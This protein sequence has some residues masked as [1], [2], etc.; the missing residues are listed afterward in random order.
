MV[1]KTRF[2][3]L[4]AALAAAL[5]TPNGAQE[6]ST[7][8]LGRWRTWG[9]GA[10]R[11]T[12]AE[13]PDGE[14]TCL[15]WTFEAPDVKKP[16][17]GLSREGLHICAHDDPP[18]NWV[19]TLRVRGAQDLPKPLS[20]T[21]NDTDKSA[22][23]STHSKIPVRKDRW[24][25]VELPL[26]CFFYAWGNDQRK[27]TSM[28][29]PDLRSLILAVPHGLKG[30]VYI[31]RIQF[32][33]RGEA[34]TCP[35]L[36]PLDFSRQP[37]KA[38]GHERDLPQYAPPSLPGFAL[39][40][41][42]KPGVPSRID[43]TPAGIATVNGRP[44]VPLGLFCVPRHFFGEV[45]RM[46]CNAMMQYRGFIKNGK[47]VIEYLD[48]CMANGMMGVVDVQT[49]T[50]TT[51]TKKADL[52]GLAD[53]VVR[54]R[55]HPALLAYYI[56]DEPEYGDVPP[57]EYVKA[58]QAIRELDPHHPVI[59]LNN[60]RTSIKTYAPACDI[61]M[62]DPYPG[63]YQTTPPRSPLV[64]IGR[65]LRDA[66]DARR[67]AVW[68]TPQLHSTHCYK[69]ELG[70]I[71]G[72]TPTLDEERFMTYAAIVHGARGFLYWCYGACRWDIRDTPKYFEAVKALFAEAMLLHRV[73]RN[74]SPFDMVATDEPIKSAAWV[75][76]DNL[77][78]IAVNESD[79][80]TKGRIHVGSPRCKAF[81]VISEDRSVGLN[82]D[83]DVEDD[84]APWGVHLYMTGQKPPTL[85]IARLLKE[86]VEPYSM[87]GTV[88]PVRERNLASYLNGAVARASSTNR[89]ARATCANNGGYGSQARWTPDGRQPP[90]H[91]L[92][93]TLR[94]S[95]SLRRVVVVAPCDDTAVS[96]LDGP[97]VYELQLAS[98]EGEWR[99]VDAQRDVYYIVWN[100]ATN[101]WERSDTHVL[102]AAKA[103][104]HSFAPTQADRIRLHFTKGKRPTLLEVE[105]YKE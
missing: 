102:G 56:A 39:P 12:L 33:Q 66:R 83:G 72:R 30:T 90:P 92:A 96:C 42:V 47:E 13:R 36:Y 64:E 97:A 60:R 63:F 85:A 2:P 98:A 76:D 68:V 54:A 59:M 62:P 84:F 10:G 26:R 80:K 15:A 44:F 95:Q 71:Y 14:G 25:E 29:I 69:D 91:W 105:A 11:I 40:P 45:K 32:E 49:F 34:P 38:Y 6:Q 99:T 70:D 31:D 24:V 65:F 58:Y 73:V 79:E 46:G 23:L 35:T 48:L 101:R 86:Y 22:W 16:P 9:P 5:A 27:G 1:S 93:I 67:G 88:S 19:L 61:L 51:K 18:G 3:L 75:L 43:L 41:L 87:A 74:G 20:M 8:G 100:E 7:T 94:G 81:H 4:V 55:S 21:L 17:R 78:I 28:R 77:Y 103:V 52:K 53:L 50:K 37:L 82:L 104:A 57:E 89:Y